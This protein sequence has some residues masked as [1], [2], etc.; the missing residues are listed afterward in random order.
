VNILTKS[1]KKALAKVCYNPWED[2]EY[3]EFLDNV[4]E[5]VNKARLFHRLSVEG[6]ADLTQRRKITIQRFLDGVTIAPQ[7]PTVFRLV[8]AVDAQI[9]VSIKSERK[10]FK[11]F[12]RFGLDL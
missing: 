6:L 7:L 3:R 11:A 4:R 9:F 1:E 5:Y 12:K 2:K 8:R 10:A